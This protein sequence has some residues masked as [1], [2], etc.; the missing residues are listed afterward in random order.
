MQITLLEISLQMIPEGGL[1]PLLLYSI[2]LLMKACL[3]L[4]YF[5]EK[6]LA[7]LIVNLLSLFI[8]IRFV[9]TAS[10]NPKS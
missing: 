4:Q 9:G 3:V 8:M 2:M 6:L 1:V 10:N 5:L 7:K